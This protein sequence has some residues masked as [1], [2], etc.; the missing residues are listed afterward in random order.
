MTIDPTKRIFIVA[1][2]Q[3]TA[4]QCDEMFR[5]IRECMF[6]QVRFMQVCVSADEDN[7]ADM[8]RVA[9]ATFELSKRIVQQYPNPRQFDADME[10]LRGMRTRIEPLK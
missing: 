1:S 3:A 8:V 2:D 9:D 6:A 5:R 10:T 7:P 4:N